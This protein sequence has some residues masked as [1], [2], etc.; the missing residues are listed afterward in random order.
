MKNAG[1][2]PGVFIFGESSAYLFS[3]SYAAVKPVS[4]IG[5]VTF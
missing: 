1:D 3:E 5:T 4:D 2:S